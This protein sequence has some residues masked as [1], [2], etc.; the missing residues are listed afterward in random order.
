MSTDITST[1][2]PRSQD[3]I[4]ARIRAAATDDWAGWRRE[5]LATALTF[6]AAEGWRKEDVTA[7]EWGDPPTLESLTADTRSYYEFALEKIANHRG[8]SAGRSVEKLTEYAWLLGRDDIVAA[9][10]AADYPQYGA[11][12]VKAFAQGLGWWADPADPEL[13]RMADGL[14]CT[15][16]CDEGCGS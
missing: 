2:Q 13:A 5:V 15:D 10:D 12:K 6:E 3:E 9:M 8:I 1:A 11:P 14:P 16:D 7:E 4:V